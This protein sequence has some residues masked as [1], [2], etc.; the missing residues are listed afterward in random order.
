M[1]LFFPEILFQPRNCH[2][3][4]TLSLHVSYLHVGSCLVDC[5]DKVGRQSPGSG[6][7]DQKT[8]FRL[9][10]EGKEQIDGGVIY[11]FIVLLDL[12]V[13]KDCVA[14]VRIGHYFF[15]SVDESFLMQL[16]EDIPD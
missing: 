7:P 12:E 13:G 4:L 11:F 8:H 6:G 3:D 1:V 9:M 2:Y 15:T 10:F 16:L 14:G 5:E